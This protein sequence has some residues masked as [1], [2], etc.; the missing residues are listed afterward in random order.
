MTTFTAETFQNEYLPSGGTHVNA[1]ITIRADGAAYAASPSIGARWPSPDRIAVV[2]IIDVS[3]SMGAPASKIKAARKATSAAIDCLSDG[4]LFAVVAGS[5]VA[6][7]VYPAQFLAP[8]TEKTRS[9]AKLA[10]RRVR[11]GGGTA[12]STWLGTTRELLIPHEGLIRQVILLTDG[13]NEGERRSELEAA[14]KRCEG[15]FR[16]D[17]RGVGTDWSID[18]LR[19]IA[20]T[21]LGSVDIVAEPHEMPADFESIVRQTMSRHTASVSLRVS[22]P[23]GASTQFVKQ[24]AP[25]IEDL[26]ERGSRVDDRTI[27]YPLGAWGTEE[28]DYHIGLSVTPH[29]VGDEMLA[30]RVSVV[31]NGETVARSQ[32]RAIWTD[33]PATST[34]LNARVAHYTGQQELASVIAEGLEAR[35]AGDGTTATHKLGR[36]AQLAAASGHDGTLKLLERVVEIEDAA[37]GTVRL[38]RQVAVADEMALGTRSTKT[39]RVRPG[40]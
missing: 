20:T 27:D 4:V 8:A 1:I 21:L 22:V 40:G 7:P 3:G 32:I 11:A 18:E 38:K 17:C 34:V 10:L 6:R 14:V 26:T 36:A 12:M 5:D 29:A 13:H 37:S 31:S 2:I 28:R 33:D 15:V 35:A 9:A 19:M 30:A 24:V 23:P 25:T 39:V 16:C